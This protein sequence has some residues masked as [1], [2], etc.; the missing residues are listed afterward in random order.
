VK[1]TPLPGPREFAATQW[2]LVGIAQSDEASQ[3]RSRKALENLCRAYWYPL[4][5]FVRNRGHSTVDAQDLTQA[6]FARFIATGGFA[7]ADRGRG[8]F[9]NYLL[10]ALKHFLA[11]EWNRARM[12]KRGG[13]M[14]LLEWDALDPERRYAL[15]PAEETNPELRFDREWALES[16]AHAVKKLREECESSRKGE[17]F[18]VLKSC[19]TSEEPPR[20]ITAARLGITE[21]AVKVA[22]HRLRRRFRQLLRDEIAETLESEKEIDEEMRYLVA[23]LRQQ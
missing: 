5:A 10:G 18:E 19:L 2:S 1:D 6:F 16:I 8:R 11:N 12:K 17:L 14:T 7:S 9:R 15:E 22:S 21:G 20:N 23:V 4:Y 3:T 13:D